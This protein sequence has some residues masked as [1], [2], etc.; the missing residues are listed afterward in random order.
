V[1]AQESL[2]ESTPAAHQDDILVPAQE[3]A[4]E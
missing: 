4:H 2:F 1:E 3:S